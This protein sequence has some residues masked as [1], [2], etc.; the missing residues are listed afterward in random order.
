MSVVQAA[1]GRCA[2]TQARDL[3]QKSRGLP[4]SSQYQHIHTDMWLIPEN[5]Q[6]AHMMQQNQTQENAVKIKA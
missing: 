2:K 1:T 6:S 5:V 4:P 3:C